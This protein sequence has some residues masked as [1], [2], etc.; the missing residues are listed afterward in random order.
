MTKFFRIIIRFIIVPGFIGTF[1]SMGVWALGFASFLV[2]I[3]TMTPEQHV[4]KTDGI[5]ILTGGS[6]RVRTGLELFRD[7]YAPHL[8]VSGVHKK[9]KL[10]DLILETGVVIPP[11]LCC[12]DLGFDATDTIGN[13]RETA[14]WVND[15]HIKTLRLVTANYHMPRA[16]LEM[17]RK[18]SDTEIHLYP[19]RTDRFQ[20]WTK[21]GMILAFS[22]YNKTWV[23]LMRLFRE[24]LVG[25]NKS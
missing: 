10:N 22:E 3:L 2:T 7:G 15:H 18:I 23:T 20:I 21:T 24:Q 14:T 5:V 25:L 6:D 11:T 8:L 4:T 16:F 1:F 9:T 12:I 19:V 13:A 17:K